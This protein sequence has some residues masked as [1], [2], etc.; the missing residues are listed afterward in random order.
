MNKKW[1]G[2]TFT[3]EMRFN[4]DRTA[5]K[6]AGNKIKEDTTKQTMVSSS[7]RAIDEQ[8]K[9]TIFAVLFIVT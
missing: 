7:T 4:L 1:R 2:V 9:N 6:R 8:L 3:D 5:V